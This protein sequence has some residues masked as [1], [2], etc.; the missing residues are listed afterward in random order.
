MDIPQKIQKL[1]ISVIK[2]MKIERLYIK[3]AKRITRAFSTNHDE[4]LFYPMVRSNRY[5]GDEFLLRRYAGINRD[6]Y[7]LIEHGVYFGNNTR[8]IPFEHEW[9]LGCILTNGD[10]RLRLLKEE[11]SNYYCE[12][13]GPLILYAPGNDNLKNK[14]SEEMKINGRVLLFFPAH[15]LGYVSPVYSIDYLATKLIKIAEINNCKNIIVSTYNSNDEIIRK[16]KEKKSGI[17]IQN[18]SCGGRYNQD[19]LINQRAIIELSTVTVSNALGTHLGNC[20]ALNKPHILIHQDISF[21]GDVESEFG[22]KSKS[23]N[24]KTQYQKE[25]SDFEKM[26]NQSESP[27]ILSPEQYSF[28]DFYWG[29]SHKIKPEEMIEIYR[30]CFEYSTKFIRHKGG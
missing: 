8:K 11:Y 5:Y 3:S 4:S 10:Y 29:F 15:G 20:V 27:A 12:A 7:A 2:R 24:W 9:E 25:V 14:L 23:D 18:Y 30:K 17:N 1:P 21:E 19:F 13:I 26:F 6:L 22:K 16:L 28:C